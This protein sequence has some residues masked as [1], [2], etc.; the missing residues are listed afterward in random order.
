MQPHLTVTVLSTLLLGAGWFTPGGAGAGEPSGHGAGEAGFLRGLRA[1]SDEP[2]LWGGAAMPTRAE[3]EVLEGVTFSLIKP[4]QP[5]VDGGRWILGVALAWHKG[6]L[7]ASYGFNKNPEE[8]TA[9]EQARGRISTD[10]GQTWGED[11]IIDRGEG[12]LGVSHGVFHQ[13]DGTL[14]AFQGAFYDHFQRTHT[15][16]YRLNEA[17]GEWEPKGVAVGDGFWPMQQPICMDNGDWIMSG[18]RVSRGFD[19]EGDFPA[20]AISDGDDWTSWDLVV[21]PTVEGLG[22]VWGESTVVVNGS[23]IVNIARYGIGQDAGGRARAMITVSE[24][25]GRT[26]TRSRP[27]NLTMATSK[28]FTGTLS[29]GQTYLL[30]TTTADSGLRRTPLRAASGIIDEF[31]GRMA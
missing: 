28:P 30:G 23:R 9:T 13:H 3:V 5:E 14:W 15:R 2:A 24:D 17:T 19:V 20:V 16:A 25:F 21:I 27:S 18:I 22:R 4:H 12:N 26:W 1:E 11:F 31:G 10:G 6:K 29:T 8:N 7:Y